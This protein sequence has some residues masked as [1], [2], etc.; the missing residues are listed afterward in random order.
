VRSD[1]AYSD[2]GC[3]DLIWGAIGPVGVRSSGYAELALAEL[4][5]VGG[6]AWRS[7]ADPSAG[8]RG[9]TYPARPNRT[10]TPAVAWE[11]PRC[12]GTSRPVSVGA[13]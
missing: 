10:V 6:W 3:P 4:C 8:F 13:A 12:V 2:V 7:P 1:L 9:W 5:T 11:T